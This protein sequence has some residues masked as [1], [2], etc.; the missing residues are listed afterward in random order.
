MM[1]YDKIRHRHSRVLAATGLP[2]V[3]FDTLPITFKYHWEE[4]HSHFTLEGKVR[5][6]ISYG[7]KTSLIPLIHDKLFFIPLYLK[8][9]PLQDFMLFSLG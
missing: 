3:E 2:P 4:Y 1:H 6:R 8:T 9:N 7:R 5:Q